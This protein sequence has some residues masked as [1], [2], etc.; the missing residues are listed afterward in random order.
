MA[1]FSKQKQKNT[2]AK[3]F[4][5]F[6]KQKNTEVLLSAIFSKHKNTEAKL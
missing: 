3:L 6:S 5:I 2:K 1:V 4:G